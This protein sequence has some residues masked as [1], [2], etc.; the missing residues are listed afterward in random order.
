MSTFDIF[1][2]LKDAFERSTKNNNLFEKALL[3]IN[4]DNQFQADEEHYFIK[5][6]LTFTTP[7]LNPFNMNWEPSGIFRDGSVLAF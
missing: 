1:N 7:S 2:N 3:S 4:W 5:D 6:D